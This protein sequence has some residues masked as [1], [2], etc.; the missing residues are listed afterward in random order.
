MTAGSLWPIGAIRRARTYCR[1]QI[2]KSSPGWRITLCE[3]WARNQ[4]GD[5]KR[6][7]GFVSGGVVTASA[8]WATYT[9]TATQERGRDDV[10]QVVFR[11]SRGGLRRVAG[12]DLVL[13]R[14]DRGGFRRVA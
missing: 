2:P 13:A 10:A 11:S 9:L 4:S 6:R 7:A 8:S 12:A 5:R 3:H 14:L 1:H